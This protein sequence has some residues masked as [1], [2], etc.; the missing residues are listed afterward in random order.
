M[1]NTV[2][3]ISSDSEHYIRYRRSYK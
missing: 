3:Y 1:Y 2:K